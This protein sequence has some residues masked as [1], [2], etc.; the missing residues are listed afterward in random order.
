MEVTTIQSSIQTAPPPGTFATQSTAM[1]AAKHAHA[2]LLN[3]LANVPGPVSDGPILIR[4]QQYLRIHQVDKMPP[5]LMSVV[6]D[7]DFW[8]FVGSNGGFTAGRVDPDH[9]IFPYQTADKILSQPKASGVL[10]LLT[11]EDVNWEPWTVDPPAH[12]ITRNL[13]KHVAG[14][15]V[16][17]EEIHHN[18][19]LALHWEIT[20]SERFGLVRNCHLENLGDRHRNIRLIDGWNH[21]LPAGVTQ[22]TYSRFSYLAAAYMRHEAVPGCGLG[23]YTLNS[24]ITDRAEPCESLR[25][26]CAWSIGLESA[27]L[28]LSDR[29]LNAFRRGHPVTAETEVRG[30]FGAH[31]LATEIGLEPGGSHQWWVVADTGLD[32]SDVSLL[33]DS[34]ENPHKLRA[35]IIADRSASVVA[36]KKRIAGAGAIQQSADSRTSVHHFANVLF[37]CMRGGTLHDNYHFPRSDFHA[38]L[39]SRNLDVL[40]NHQE[41]LQT[42]P[43][44]CALAELTNLAAECGDAQLSRL[45]G[46]YLPICFSRRHGDPSRPWNRFEIHTKDADGRPLFAYAGNWRD[47]FQNWESLAYSYP[48]CF[49]PMISIFLNASTA[50]GYNPYR[51]TRAG[52]DWEVFDASDPWSHIGYWGDHQ[53]IYLLR[54]LEGQEHFNPGRITSQ[55]NQR[56]HTYAHVPYEIG[57][58]EQL[59]QD[60]KHSIHFN[61]TLHQQLIDRARILG[62]DGKLLTDANQEIILVS[63]AE[64]LLVPLLVKLSNLV[65]GGGIWLNTQRPEWND[66]NNALAG[67]GL[68]VVT[69]C[70]MRR[71]LMFLETLLGDQ[72]PET[73]DLSKP[74]AELLA[75]LTEILPLATEPDLDDFTRLRLTRALGQAGEKHRTAVYAGEPVQFVSVGTPSL[76]DFI[77][78]ALAAVDATL[79]ANRREDQLFHSYNLLQVDAP[80][81]SIHR[82]DLM[83]EGQVAVL[84]SGA[85]KPAEA[86]RLMKAMRASAIY[87]PDQNSYLLYPDRIITPFLERNT[88]PSDWKTKIPQLAISILAGD[89]DLIRIDEGGRAHFHPDLTN[90]RDLQGKLDGMAADPEWQQIIGADRACVLELWE[91]VFNHRSFTGRSGAMFGFEGLGSIYWHMVAKLLLALQEVHLQASCESPDSAEVALLTE[92]YEDI[93]NG[94]GF[95]KSSETYGAFPTDPYSHSPR[96]R[97]AQQPGMTGQVK[98]EILTRMGE[99]GV[100]VRNGQIHFEPTLLKR[101][102]FF[103]ISHEFAYHG[104]DGNPRVWKLGPETLAFT[105]CQVP[106]CYELSDHAS[107]TLERLNGGSET[108]AGACLAADVSAHIFLR[109][110]SIQ[111]LLVKVPQSRFSL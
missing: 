69:V 86:L 65:P 101:S 76:R 80:K 96:D 72:A 14:T 70:Y 61:K 13:Y 43:D 9:A 74:V 103:T 44:P 35:E 1:P 21:L 67:W 20:A 11:C 68:S 40:R 30:V 19:E 12:G 57:G 60:P 97:G 93:R 77:D 27:T 102:E 25:V 95:T 63:L 42:L 56:G 18:L 7:S 4:D 45:A 109:D 99:L 23:I 33:R 37:N 10:S 15:S 110:D 104:V 64:K 108:F 2:N 29:Q 83:L 87:R 88:L 62:G 22:E 75:R 53:I 71:Y 16:I 5:F 92:V 106:V 32:H 66:A 100:H 46:E 26:S 78:N 81:A 51:I 85:L 82:L 55:L 36:L 54:L 84:S 98:E 79:A 31:L 111:R 28:L 34:L 47:I 8:L 107:I 48:V 89:R 105:F 24:G 3:P 94:L 6:S 49:E 39:K 17:F 50:D 52:I 59:L 41:W 58:F 73:L 38:F 90:A 91:Q